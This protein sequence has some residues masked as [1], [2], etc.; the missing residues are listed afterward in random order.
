MIFAR[1]LLFL[2]LF[3]VAAVAADRDLA[4]EDGEQLTFR[5][6]WGVFGNAGEIKIRGAAET[7]DGA[8]FLAVTT[9]T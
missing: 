1:I 8:P 2:P 3:V 6:A 4:L 5:V 9:T 7:N